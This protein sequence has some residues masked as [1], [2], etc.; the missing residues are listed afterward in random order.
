[1]RALLLIVM[2]LPQVVLA[3]I[4]VCVDPETGKKSFTD[5]ACGMHG[6][7][8]K[9]KVKEGNF[10]ASGS[11]VNSGMRGD[12]WRS[13][14]GSDISTSD[15]Y[16]GARRNIESAKTAGSSSGRDIDS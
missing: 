12:T 7:G 16:K 8:D 4:Y 9:I 3:E 15:N 13:E 5:T 6:T 11:N 1:M 10:G 2:L 14:D